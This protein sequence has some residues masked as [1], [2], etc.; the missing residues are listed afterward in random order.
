MIKYKFR[1]D[2][3]HPEFKFI[4]ELPI[5]YEYKIVMVEDTIR[6]IGISLNKP[7]IGFILRDSK[8][9]EIEL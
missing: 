6:I 8:L 5:D 2:E 1:T 9:E 3:Y 7:P 4:G